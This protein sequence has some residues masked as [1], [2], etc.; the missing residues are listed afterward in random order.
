MSDIHIPSLDNLRLSQNFSSQAGVKKIVTTIPVR[1][2]GKQDFIRTHPDPGFRIDTAV[3]ELKEEHETYLVSPE[4]LGELPSEWVPKTLVTY[5]NRQGVLALW[6]IRLP[7]SDGRIDQWN[8]TAREAASLAQNDW[9]RVSA[10]MS[11]GAYEIFTAIGEIP[12]PEW[13]DIG[14][15]EVLQIA[16]KANYISSLDHPVIKALKGV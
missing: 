15:E 12:D 4:I 9:V 13:P 3:I 10:N 14:F 16:F 5:I 2:P 1:K 8:D 6:P 7:G 11:L